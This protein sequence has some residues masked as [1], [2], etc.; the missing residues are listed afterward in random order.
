[1]LF[2]RTLTVAVLAW[3][4]LATGD[5]KKVS[6]APSELSRTTVVLNVVV[7]CEGGRNGV[8]HPAVGAG[9]VFVWKTYPQ[10][11][12]VTDIDPPTSVGTWVNSD[13]TGAARLQIVVD[14]EYNNKI[15]LWIYVGGQSAWSREHVFN[16]SEIQNLSTDAQGV[17]TFPA[18]ATT[19][20]QYHVNW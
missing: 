8:G 17:K 11:A 2:R 16:W 7:N 15:V 14:V 13:A 12:N 4:S 5:C 10:A 20:Y 1:M 18:S 9:V 3:L 6:E 19:F